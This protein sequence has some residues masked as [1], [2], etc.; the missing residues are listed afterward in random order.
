MQKEPN[1][2]KVLFIASNIPTPKRKSNL[3]VMTIAHKLSTWF[4][5]SVM[6][7]AERAP[8]P[9]YLMKKY[10]NIAGKQSWEDNGIIVRP[11][12]YIRLVGASNAFRLLP[13]YVGKTKKFCKEHGIP[14]LVHAHYALPDGYLAYQLFKTYG[15]PYLISFRKSDIKLLQTKCSSITYKMMRTVLEHASQIIVHNA[16]QQE[17]LS[18]SGFKSILIPHGIEKDFFAK[19]DHANTSDNIAIAS[20]GEL[21]PTKHIHW[22]VQA[23]KNYKGNKKV[24]LKTAGEGPMRP[25]LEAMAKGYDNIQILGKIDHDEVGKL[26]QKTDVFALPS[27]NETFGLVYLEAA[28]HQNAAIATKGTGIWGVFDDQKEML[29]CDSEVSFDQLL[30]RLI[31]DDNYRNKLAENAYLKASQYYQWESVIKKYVELYDELIKKN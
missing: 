15:V 13:H 19:K 23:V 9:I 7:P 18:D 16:A 24:T 21:V 12:K 20:I 1:K 22:V 17:L 8:F 27:V 30:Y 6:H 26:L 28:A 3:V 14:Q 2:P 29:F 10:R 11:F 4:D 31:D 25:E 5:I